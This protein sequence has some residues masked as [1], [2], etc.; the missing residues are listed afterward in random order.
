VTQELLVAR[1]HIRSVYH[2]CLKRWHCDAAA[3]LDGV[4]C[5]IAG[6]PGLESERKA[7]ALLKE[8]LEVVDALSATER[9]GKRSTGASSWVHRRVKADNISL[10]TV[11]K[12]AKEAVPLLMGSHLTVGI[13]RKLN[14]LEQAEFILA[15]MERWSENVTN[16]DIEWG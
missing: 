15:K 14:G 4:G 1:I 7:F 16:E 5:C 9:V 11:L 6:H 10:E 12:I 13:A 3:V 8:G 2:D